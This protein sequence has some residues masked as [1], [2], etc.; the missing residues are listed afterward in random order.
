M[1]R[2]TATLDENMVNT[3]AELTGISETPTLLRLG[4]AT[5]IQVESAKRLAALGGS[6]P[7]AQAAPRH[8]DDRR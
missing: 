2:T 7:Q 1:M 3:A 5:L 8:R 4:L 6:D